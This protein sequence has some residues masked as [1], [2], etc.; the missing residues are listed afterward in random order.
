MVTKRP[1]GKSSIIMLLR[2]E[3]HFAGSRA[4]LRQRPQHTARRGHENCRRR[5]LARDIGQN[6]TPASVAQRDEVIPVAADRAYWNRHPGYSE[7]RDQRRSARQQ[8]LLNRTSFFGFTAHALA[9]FALIT[10]APSVVNC[11]G[12]V[13]AQ[14]LQQ[15]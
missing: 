10:E 12:D 5:A 15:T 3:Q 1:L 4:G 7:P 14:S 9:Q 13:I 2:R 8:S 6:Q 11:D